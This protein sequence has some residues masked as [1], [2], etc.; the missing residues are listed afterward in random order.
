M[1]TPTAGPRAE[2]PLPSVF[3]ALLSE[4]PVEAQ[5]RERFGWVYGLTGACCVPAVAMAASMEPWDPKGV[6]LFGA[7]GLACGVA[8]VVRRRSAATLAVRAGQVGVYR[9]GARVGAFRVGQ[10][11]RLVGTGRRAARPLAAC[12]LLALMGLLPLVLE[13]RHP[14]E[15]V[16]I[17]A[18]LLALA[19]GSAWSVVHTELRLMHFLL[20]RQPFAE[21]VLL[22]P[23]DAARLLGTSHGPQR[24]AASGPPG[25]ASPPPP[26]ARR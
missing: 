22:T 9:R 25:A 24:P 6:A 17:C 15:V 23:E 2:S 16:A 4:V 19:G 20:P 13:K 12:A 5:A 1:A 21:K 26:A 8:E 7:I 3:P 18:A 11:T 14:L 10:L